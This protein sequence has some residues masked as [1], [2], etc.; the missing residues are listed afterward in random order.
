MTL[1]NGAVVGALGD[2]WARQLGSGDGWRWPRSSTGGG[3]RVDELAVPWWVVA[4][5]MV[6][7]VV[8][9]TAAAWWPAREVARVPAVRALSG[10]PPEP[11]PARRA[12]VLAAASVA[13]GIGCLAMSGSVADDRGVDWINALLV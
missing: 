2:G 6:L 9:G 10:R 5:A 7:A 8:A 4:G 3:Y 12:A 13:V 11:K 1:T